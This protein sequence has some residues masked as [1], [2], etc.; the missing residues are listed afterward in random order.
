MVFMHNMDEKEPGSKGRLK[1]GVVIILSPT[2]VI[3]WREAGT[4]LRITM[5]LE[6]SFAGR[7]IGFNL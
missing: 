4:K 5:L 6:S 2:A 7:F 3:A 1:G